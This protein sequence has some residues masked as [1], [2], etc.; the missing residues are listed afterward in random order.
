MMNPIE[1]SDVAAFLPDLKGVQS[2]IW[3]EGRGMLYLEFRNGPSWESHPIQT[4]RLWNNGGEIGV[5]LVNS[6]ELA[7]FAPLNCFYE[8][9]NA[10]TVALRILDILREGEIDFSRRE[11]DWRVA[12]A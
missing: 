2:T 12:S 7:R 10:P 9:L 1:L 11:E 4:F 6:P 3:I 5:Q 8:D